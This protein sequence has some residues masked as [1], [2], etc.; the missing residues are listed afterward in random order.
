MPRFYFHLKNDLI[1][2]D[3]EG[4]ELSDIEAALGEARRDVRALAAEQVRQGRLVL[5][6]HIDIADPTGRVVATVTFGDAM[7]IEA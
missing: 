4:R 1:V 7:E 2:D 5:H 3:L 6:H